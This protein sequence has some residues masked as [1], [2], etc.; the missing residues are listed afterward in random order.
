[1]ADSIEKQ[2]EILELIAES[3]LSYRHS[4][5][6]GTFVFH[7]LKQL[8]FDELE[9]SSRCMEIKVVCRFMRV[10]FIICSFSM[11]NARATEEWS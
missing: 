6:F 4:L 3:K 5:P 10:N 11:I 9:N 8:E 1:V 7:P 2:F